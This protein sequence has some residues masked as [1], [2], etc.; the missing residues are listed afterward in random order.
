MTKMNIFKQTLL[1]KEVAEMYSGICSNV[2]DSLQDNIHLSWETLLSDETEKHGNVRP[3][4]LSCPD[5]TH[6]PTMETAT[7]VGHNMY[8]LLDVANGKVLDKE[9]KP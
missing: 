3:I 5:K 9:K 6:E 1:A 4:D 8:M 2:E 7:T